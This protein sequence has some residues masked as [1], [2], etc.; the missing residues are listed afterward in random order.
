MR[1]VTSQK[2]PWMPM[3]RPESVPLSYGQQRLWFINQF[4][5]PSPTYNVPLVLRLSGTLDRDALQAA[6]ADVVE[7]HEVLRTVFAETDGV[8]QQDVRPVGERV[9][10]VLWSQ[11]PEPEL[12]DRVELA[13]GYPFDVAT[14]MLMR[15]EVLTTDTNLFTA[16]LNLA[17]AQQSAALTLVQLY[18][19]L[20]GGWQ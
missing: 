15:A 2:M 9:P 5:G 4:E 19:A 3:T 17:T 20:G 7:R 13:C 6:L 18:S 14:D 10:V 11:V 8:P 12:A 1:P 16:Q